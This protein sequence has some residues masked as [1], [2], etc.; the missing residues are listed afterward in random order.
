MITYK[1]ACR[2]IKDIKEKDFPEN[3]KVKAFD[4]SDR[5]AF[6]FYYDEKTLYGGLPRFFVYKE[7]GEIEAF[8]IPPMENLKLLQTSKEIEF[9]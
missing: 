2:L 7:N 3:V 9:E 4:L 5:W 1:K 6:E 8:S